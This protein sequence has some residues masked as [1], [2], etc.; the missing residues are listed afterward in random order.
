LAT[1][2]IGIY[3]VRTRQIRQTNRRLKAMVEERT[4]ELETKNGELKEKNEEIAAQNEELVQSEEEISSQRDQLAAQNEELHL[5]REELASQNEKLQDA[6]SVIEEQNQNLEGEVAKRTLALTVQ[7][8]QL[9]QFAFIASHNLRG[10]V[11]RMLGLGKLV[12]AGAI[13]DNEKEYVMNNLLENTKELDTVVRDLSHILDIRNTQQ[14][15]TT[16]DLAKEL[17]LAEHTLAAEIAEAGAVVMADFAQLESL[18]TVRPYIQ[19]IFLNLL[20]NAIKYRDPERPL[21]VRVKAQAEGKFVRIS[22][23]DNGLGID[24]ERDGGKLFTL[25]ARFHFDVK[26]KGMSL[27]LVKT[28]LEAM[29]GRIEAESTVGKGTTFNLY[30]K[31]EGK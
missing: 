16:T 28:Q 27:F 5:S 12:G 14:Q 29:G 18:E 22:F 9:E 15:I 7:N 2:V 20:D 26:G 8:Q 30:L 13:A 19:S 3:L 1:T 6:Q 11:A 23:A 21:V 10:P 4:K 31:M 24:M 25:Y 17:A